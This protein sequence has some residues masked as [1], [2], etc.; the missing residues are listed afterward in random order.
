M[1][2][3]SQKNLNIATFKN[4]PHLILFTITLFTILLIGLLDK[5]LLGRYLGSIVALSLDPFVYISALLLG[6][7]TPYNR[8]IKIL[9]ITTPLVSILVSLLVMEWSGRFNL[10]ATFIR[11]VGFI[12]EVH[13][14]NAI[15]LL[16]KKI[17]KH[18]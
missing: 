14:I 1:N 11:G 8:L 4:N 10:E 13:L 3:N 17:R 7:I 6:F 18:Q 2:E 15:Y 12:I 9:V 5:N 16:V